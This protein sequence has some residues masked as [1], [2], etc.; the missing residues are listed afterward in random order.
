[1]FTDVRS[2]LSSSK[3]FCTCSLQLQKLRT[4]DGVWIAVTV[5]N[6]VNFVHTVGEVDPCESIIKRKRRMSQTLIGTKK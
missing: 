2:V 1:V 3:T 5:G 4:Q 6:A